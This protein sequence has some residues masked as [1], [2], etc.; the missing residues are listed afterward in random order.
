MP[1]TC[2]EGVQ[3]KIQLSELEKTENEQL[4]A[5]L[6]TNNARRT[7]RRGNVISEKTEE[8]PV[9]CFRVM[10]FS[11]AF[12]ISQQHGMMFDTTDNEDE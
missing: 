9:N 2:A 1:L 10:S 4:I 8:L 5:L 12:N 7:W 3:V 11:G 6:N